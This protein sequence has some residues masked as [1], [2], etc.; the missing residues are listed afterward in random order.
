MMIYIYSFSLLVLAELFGILRDIYLVKHKI[1]IVSFLI[2]KNDS[3]WSIE[4]EKIL[5]KHE[6]I[7][8]EQAKRMLYVFFY[9]RYFFQ[10][11]FIGYKT[12]PLEIEARHKAGEQIIR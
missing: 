4:D 10:L 1:F 7:H 3:T 2:I 9:L 6:L 12:M 11:I 8:F 5:L